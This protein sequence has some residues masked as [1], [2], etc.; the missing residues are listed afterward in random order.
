VA[1]AGTRVVD[2]SHGVAAVGNI[3]TAPQHRR[4]AYG[5]KVTAAVVK[6]LV[7]L[8]FDTIVLNVEMANQPAIDI[9]LSLDFMPYCGFCEGISVL[10]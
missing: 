7:E 4:R 6:R 5:I 3:F 8:R 2:P 1:V 9:Y 10:T